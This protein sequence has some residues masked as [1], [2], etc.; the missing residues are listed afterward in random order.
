MKRAIPINRD[1]QEND[2][3]GEFSRYIGTGYL[4]TEKQIINR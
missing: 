4:S 3:D 1:T 2:C